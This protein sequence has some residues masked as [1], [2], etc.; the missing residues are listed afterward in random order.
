MNLSRTQDGLRAWTCAEWGDN[1]QQNCRDYTFFSL[2]TFSL[3]LL[4]R[5]FQSRSGWREETDVRKFIKAA[6]DKYLTPILFSRLSHFYLSRLR[7]MLDFLFVLIRIL[8]G[9]FHEAK[10]I[11]RRNYL[12][13]TTRKNHCAS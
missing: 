6:R 13:L 7:L 4:S 8:V 10:K 11:K 1:F 2:E 9:F 5:R 12:I 3:T